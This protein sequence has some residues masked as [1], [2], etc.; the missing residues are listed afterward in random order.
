[1]NKCC[2]DKGC[3]GKCHHGDWDLFEKVPGQNQASN[4]WDIADIEF[5]V[6]VVVVV[7]VVYSHFQVK[8]N[9]GKVIRLG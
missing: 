9:F 2:K 1:M 5:L 3:P 4:S 7:L 8:P 6:L